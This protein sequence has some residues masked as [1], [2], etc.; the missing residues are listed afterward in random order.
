MRTGIQEIFNIII[1][2]HHRILQFLTI[3]LIGSLLEAYETIY[4]FYTL[5]GEPANYEFGARAHM[6]SHVFHI[7]KQLGAMRLVG[8]EG[9]KKG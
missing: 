3:H 8:Y 6:Q 1:Y 9:P 7:N 4:H 2:T 5:F